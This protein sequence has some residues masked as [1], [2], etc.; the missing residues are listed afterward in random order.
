MGVFVQQK[1]KGIEAL[2]VIGA[3]GVCC[4]LG[5]QLFGL[6]LPTAITGN[7]DAVTAAEYEAG[8]DRVLA[9]AKPLGSSMALLDSKGCVWEVSEFN[10]KL[11]LTR[12]LK[13][14]GAPVC[15]SKQKGD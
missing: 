14:D 9:D 5:Y 6:K 12:Y 7:V 13:P 3:I 1:S 10:E 2:K 4:V 11:N 8:H 15:A